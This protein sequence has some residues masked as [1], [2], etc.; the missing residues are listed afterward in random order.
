MREVN[1]DDLVAFI[2]GLEKQNKEAYK[3]GRITLEQLQRE[4]K[5]SDLIKQWVLQSAQHPTTLKG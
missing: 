2:T 4:F 5:Q 3:R 1:A